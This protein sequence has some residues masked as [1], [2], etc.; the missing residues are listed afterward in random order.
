M[1]HFEHGGLFGVELLNYFMSTLM[2]YVKRFRVTT[3]RFINR[4]VETTVGTGLYGA[5]DGIEFCLGN[6]DKPHGR[7]L[8]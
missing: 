7:M 5:N 8:S 2:I 6:V 4:K 3:V 1:V